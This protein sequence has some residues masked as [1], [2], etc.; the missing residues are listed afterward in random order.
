[1]SAVQKVRS[2]SARA[3][4]PHRL[5]QSID[6][7]SITATHDN[8]PLRSAR[9]LSVQI[10]GAAQINALAGL[11]DEKA[12]MLLDLYQHN[13]TW[14]VGAVVQGFSGGLADLVKHLGGEVADEPTAAAPP[15]PS[16]VAPPPPPPPVSLSKIDLRKQK[17]GVT[18]K[19]LGIEHEMAEVKF[20]IDASGSMAGLYAD[21]TV[22]ETVERLAPVSLRLDQD[23]VMPTWFYASECKRVEDL[24]ATN[25]EG[26]VSRTCPSPGAKIGAQPTGE[27]GMFGGARTRGGK[28]IGYGN[29]EP[30]VMNAIL[31]QEPPVRTEPLLIIFVTDGGITRSAEIADILTRTSNRPIFW[32]FVG[33]GKANYG[34]LRKLD[35]LPGRVVDN[36]GFFSVDDLTKISDDELYERILFEFPQWLKD[37]RQHNILR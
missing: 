36:A 12:L 11:G 30:L 9:A 13:G 31:A 28:S 8:M 19:K 7:I 10:A 21:G 22:Q 33:V 23:G 24:T 2:P 3:A 6:R 15:A 37:A 1:M 32:Q 35:T 27:K 26:F 20:V 4:T 14:R 18:L 25:L 29:N 34:I 5:P 17:V 16:P